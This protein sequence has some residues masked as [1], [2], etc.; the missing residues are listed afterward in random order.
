[1][2]AENNLGHRI[3]VSGSHRSAR[4]L[5]SWVTGEDRPI[6]SFSLLITS[7]KSNSNSNFH[8]RDVSRSGHHSRFVVADEGL[9]VLKA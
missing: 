5:C 8:G 9:P 4:P 7:S 6:A 3:G 1:M 2:Q